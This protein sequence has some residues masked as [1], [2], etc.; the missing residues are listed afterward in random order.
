MTKV[1]KR[2]E[3]IIAKMRK[4]GHRLTPQRMAI[5][6]ILIGN[7]QHPTVKEIHTEVKKDFPMTSL[8]TTYKMVNL[9][10]EMGE[11]LEIDRGN[12]QAHYDGLTAEPHPHLICTHCHSIT[13]LEIPTLKKIPQEI[14]DNTG[15]KITHY[16]FD[17]LGI[18][19]AC[20]RTNEQDV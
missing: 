7:K 11:I 3:R 8:A 19:P 16:Q 9:L 17:L 13:D 15:Y 1:T 5:L 20:Q 4:Q 2:L 12:N 18:C 6:N 10:T 14:T